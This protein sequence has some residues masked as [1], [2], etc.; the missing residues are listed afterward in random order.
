MRDYIKLHRH[1]I[2]PTA[3]ATGL[4]LRANTYDKFNGFIAVTGCRLAVES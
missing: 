3:L 1:C 2:S 4:P